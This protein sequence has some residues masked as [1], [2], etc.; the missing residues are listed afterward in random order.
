MS[1]LFIIG[2]GFDIAHGN[3]TSYR[4]F[5]D[6]LIEQLE[7]YGILGDNL[8]EIP[9]IPFP[10]MGHHDVEFDREETVKLLMWLLQFGCGSSLY[11]GDP[12]LSGRMWKECDVEAQLL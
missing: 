1:R 5:R 12:G 11:E 4:Y 9:E 7:Q 6:R 2:N 10:S 3:K 8:D